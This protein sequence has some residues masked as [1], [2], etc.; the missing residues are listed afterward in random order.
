M[1]PPGPVRSGSGCSVSATSPTADN[2]EDAA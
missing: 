2:S 1:T